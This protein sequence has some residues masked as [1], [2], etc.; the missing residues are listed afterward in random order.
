MF[1]NIFLPPWSLSGGTVLVKQLFK[2]VWP[3]YTHDVCTLISVLPVFLPR[4][5][6]FFKN[7]DLFWG[8]YFTYNCANLELTVV[9]CNL[10]EV[11]ERRG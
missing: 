5:I 7:N 9:R 1:T 4:P 6:Y 2:L 10:T 11:N 8:R 3:Y